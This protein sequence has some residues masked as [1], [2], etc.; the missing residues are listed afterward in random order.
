MVGWIKHHGAQYENEVT[1][2]TTHLIC[3][4]AE[5]KKKTAQGDYKA[6]LDTQGFY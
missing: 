5:Y 2:Q 1:D 3:T 6:A 4:I